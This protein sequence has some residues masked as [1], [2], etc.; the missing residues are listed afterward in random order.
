[1]MYLDNAATTLYKP[2]TVGEA[3]KDAV[4]HHLYGN[5]GRGTYD[6]A[7][8]SA[9]LILQT[10]KLIRDFFHADETYEVVFQN[11]ATMGLN[12]LLKGLL[13]PGDHALTTSWDHNAI[14]RPL[15]QLQKNEITFSLINSEPATGTLFYQ[16]LEQKLRPETKLFI[17]SHASNV[18]GNVLDLDQ[19][20]TFCQ[21]H[22][23]LLIVD[24]AQ[25][26]GQVEIDLHD[27]LIDAICF[28]GHK[29]LYGPTGI[30]GICLKKALPV[31]PLLSGGDGIRSFDK[32]QFPQLPS[33][34]EAGTPNIPGIMGLAKGIEYVKQKGIATI[35]KQMDTFTSILYHRLHSNSNFT[36][37]GDFS[38]PH[39]GTVSFNYRTIDS[40]QIADYL[41]EH[42]QIAT[43]SG[44]H[45]A[46]KMHEALGT[47]KQGTVRLSFST[48]NTPEEI[49]QLVSI[50]ES[51]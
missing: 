47:A 6:F 14:L 33:L 12:T 19:I 50:L 13:V 9:R 32:E 39:V 31:T 41:W 11:S 10:R 20:K 7:L 2:D 46:P 35:Q 3:M 1:M 16:E 18:T 51:I 15:Y 34:L 42:H 28:T 27:H 43:R 22:Q 5:P 49:N 37:Y 8:N 17:C 48:F 38:G 36:L 44:Y 29:S 4:N 24:V 45:C 25:T 30:G 40:A 21:K 23:L 26:A